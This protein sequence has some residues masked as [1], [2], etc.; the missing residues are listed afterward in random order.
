MTDEWWIARCKDSGELTV[1]L[2]DDKHAE[3]F[4]GVSYIGTDWGGDYDDFLK[5]YIPLKKID[6][7][8][9]VGD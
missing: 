7:E 9:L 8:E 3:A 1:V 4:S 5:Y 6:L 2:I